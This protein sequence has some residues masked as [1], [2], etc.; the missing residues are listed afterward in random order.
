[1]GASW[2]VLIPGTSK[3]ALLAALSK[4]KVKKGA[5]KEQGSG[6]VLPGVQSR[7]SRGK[8]LSNYVDESLV[9]HAE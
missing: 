8:D 7:R 9:T 2:Y 3:K 4:P 1:M 5:Q 6:K